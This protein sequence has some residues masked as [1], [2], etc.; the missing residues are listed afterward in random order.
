MLPRHSISG[1]PWPNF[2]CASNTPKSTG[3][4]SHGRLHPSAN[5][6]S[7]VDIRQVYQHRCQKVHEKYMVAYHGHNLNNFCEKFQ[8]GTAAHVIINFITLNSWQRRIWATKK[9]L[10]SISSKRIRFNHRPLPF[11]LLNT[12]IYAVKTF[13]SILLDESPSFGIFQTNVT[14]Y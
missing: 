12:S 3:F 10:S 2:G 5:D 11:T 6:K 4:F 13:V 1:P 8:L 14:L 7:D 9:R